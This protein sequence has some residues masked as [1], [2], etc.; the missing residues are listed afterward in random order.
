MKE[1]FSPEVMGV[2]NIPLILF[3]FVVKTE[4]IFQ[5]NCLLKTVVD[6]CENLLQ[7]SK[8]QIY[9]RLKAELF[10]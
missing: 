9:F 6:R 3:E 1:R 5:L 7:G 2:F 4:D 10:Q 8:E